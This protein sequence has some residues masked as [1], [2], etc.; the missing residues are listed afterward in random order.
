[1]ISIG[2]PPSL[3]SVEGG[4]VRGRG[5]EERRGSYGLDIE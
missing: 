4:D 1:M 3:K 5:W 2:S